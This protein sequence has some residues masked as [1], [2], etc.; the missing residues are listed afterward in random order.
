MHM[1][2]CPALSQH[3]CHSQGATL[4]LP[5]KSPASPSLQVADFGISRVLS[6]AACRTATIGTV[7]CAANGAGATPGQM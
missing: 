3:R 6:A 7:R 5:K 1:R 4:S 2:C